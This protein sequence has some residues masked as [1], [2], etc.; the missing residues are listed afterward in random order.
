[1]PVR[2][3]IPKVPTDLLMQIS[4]FELGLPPDTSLDT[5]MQHFSTARDVFENRDG[6]AR[7]ELGLAMPRSCRTPETMLMFRL[8]H[9]FRHKEVWFANNMQL[10]TVLELIKEE[11]GP[12]RWAH[13]PNSKIGLHK[14]HCK[15]VWYNPSWPLYRCVPSLHV[16]RHPSVTPVILASNTDEFRLVIAN[17]NHRWSMQ[18]IGTC[19]GTDPVKWF[20][21]AH[22]THWGH[23]EPRGK[24]QPTR[25]RRRLLPTGSALIFGVP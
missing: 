3:T 14:R 13:D 12:S 2:I 11:L 5:M 8:F 18:M 10:E 23:T 22:H 17:G 6:A 1:M 20:T 7:S 15:T 19:Y 21:N 24:S 25:K 16:N 4:L 9:P